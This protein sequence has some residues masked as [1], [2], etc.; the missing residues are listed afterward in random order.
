MRLKEKYLLS[1][2]E[3]L[4]ACLLLW[5]KMYGSTALNSAQNQGLGLSV[6]E[7][8]SWSACKEDRP[9]SVQECRLTY[10]ARLLLL[11]DSNI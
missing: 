8:S 7:V 10:V 6:I 2:F 9:P 4:K 11:L 5:K 3:N 1:R